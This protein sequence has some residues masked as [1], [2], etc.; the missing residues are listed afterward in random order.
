ML[1]VQTWSF[2]E[3]GVLP[4]CHNTQDHSETDMVPSMDQIELFD[5]SSVRKQ[6]TDIYLN[7]SCLIAIFASF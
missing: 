4:Y 1:R 2:G 7:C 5:H 3:Y 6:M